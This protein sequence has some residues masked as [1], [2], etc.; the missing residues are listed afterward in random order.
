MM[1]GKIRFYGGAGEKVCRLEHDGFS[2]EAIPKKVTN[3]GKGRGSCSNLQTLS[4]RPAN[5]GFRPKLID[6][7]RSLK[8]MSQAHIV[9]PTAH[10]CCQ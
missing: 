2:D 9:L 8:P 7:I 5:T 1:I 3:K 6:T 4:V 10:I